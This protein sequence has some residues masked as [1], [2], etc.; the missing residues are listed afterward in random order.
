MINSFSILH[1]AKY[2]K[3]LGVKFNQVSD[4]QNT[5]NLT[6]NGKYGQWRM[7]MGIQ[8]SGSTSKL[9]LMAPNLGTIA[10][11][12]RQECLEALLAVNYRIALGNFGFDPLDGEVRLEENIPLAEHSITF[13]QFRLAFS[14]LLQTVTIYQNLLPLIISSDMSAQEAVQ[15]CEDDFF[16]KN[17]YDISATISQ[18]I[19]QEPDSSE[20]IAEPSELVVEE[21]LEE[22][23]R[24]G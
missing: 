11:Q 12:K 14:A 19:E 4:V 21:V 13:E 16:N 18:V 5:I 17:N 6:F 23:E 9:M 1:V 3:Q 15:A 7:I 22:V 2:L 24:E 8:H 20:E 10:T